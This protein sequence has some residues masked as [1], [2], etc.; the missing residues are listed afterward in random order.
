[1]SNVIEL[2][3]LSLNLFIDFI[4]SG[5]RLRFYIEFAIRIAQFLSIYKGWQMERGRMLSLFC[6]SLFLVVIINPI[7]WLYNAQWQP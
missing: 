7:M 4:I 2:Y 6:H 5:Q 1:M 3:I